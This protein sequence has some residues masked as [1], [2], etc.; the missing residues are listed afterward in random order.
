MEQLGITKII[1]HS[2]YC[3]REYIGVGEYEQP[4]TFEALIEKVSYVLGENVR[5][6]KHLDRAI[7]RVGILTGAG[8]LSDYVKDAYD[9]NC[10]VYITGEKTLYS[11]QYAK[12]LG[13]NMIVGSHTFT[14]V[15]GVQSFVHELK[16]RF[17]ELEIH[18][19][20]ED[21]IE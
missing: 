1:R 18:Q 11:I 9:A 2:Y 14:E 7:R 12:H 21:H 17:S 15:F 4:M 8:H 5:S 20:I 3:E 13:M 19:L 6:W 16:T 10:D